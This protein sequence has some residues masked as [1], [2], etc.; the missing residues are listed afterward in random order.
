MAAMASPG[1]GYSAEVKLTLIID[2]LRIEI[3]A[4]GPRRF[5]ARHPINLPPCSAQLEMVVD[6]Q[7]ELLPVILPSGMK[8]DRP[9]IP[10]Q[11]PRATDKKTIELPDLRSIFDPTWID[12]LQSSDE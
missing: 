5:T 11:I 7:I 8:S 2:D 6:D 10:V 4:A 12:S 9:T 3:A 1:A